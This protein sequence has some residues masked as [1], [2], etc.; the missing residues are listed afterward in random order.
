MRELM[1]NGKRLCLATAIAVSMSAVWGMSQEASASTDAD[2]ELAGMEVQ[3]EEIASLEQGPIVRRQLLYRASR[4][5][6]EPKMTFTLND[7]Y[8]RN[9]IVGLSGSYF[10][11]NSFGFGASAG[12]GLVNRS[13]NLRHHLESQ[14]TEAQRDGTSYS[15]VSFLADAGLIWVPAFGKLSVLNSMFSHYDFHIIGGMGFINQGAETASGG[16][17]PDSELRGMQPAPLLGAGLRFF[18]ADRV[19]MNFQLRNYMNFN[20]AEISRGDANPRLGLTTTFSVGLGF[21][22]PVDVHISR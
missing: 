3:E 9:G 10:L 12:V 17:N 22:L 4:L 18:M 6:L 16:G 15:H 14:M 8:V 19:A 7:T 11:N 1:D 2:E 21:Y 20:H 5:E 13:T